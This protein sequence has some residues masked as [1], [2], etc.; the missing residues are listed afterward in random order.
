MKVRAS[1]LVSLHLF[2]FVTCFSQE[3]KTLSPDEWRQDINF[4][5]NTI[6]EVH[7]NPYWRITKESFLS[8][9]NELLKELKGMSP[10]DIQVRMIQLVASIQDGHSSLSPYGPNGFKSIFPI[11]TYQ[12]TDG[13]FITAISKEYE[14]LAGAEILKIGHLDTPS[15]LHLISTLWTNENEFEKLNGAVF[16]LTSPEALKSLKIINDINVLT[17]TV[18]LRSGEEQTIS[19]RRI[20]QEFDLSF[21]YWGEMW[22]PGE[23]EYVTGIDFLNSNSYYDQENVDLPL[24]LRYRS[25]FWFKYL[26]KERLIYLQI[27]SMGD[28]RK[29]SLSSFLNRLWA[30]V[31]TKPVDKFV[32]DIRYNV[33]GDGSR[34]NDILH[35]F[36]KRDEI[37]KSD[38]LFT[39]LGRAT[40]SAGVNLASA[41]K[42]H[43]NTTFIGSPA[44]AY[45]NHNGDAETFV[46]PNSKM[47]L[48]VSTSWHQPF[49]SRDTNRLIP[50]D[51]PIMLSS[52]EYFGKV[53][54]IMTSILNDNYQPIKD[55]IL[56]QNAAIGIR[57]YNNR[58]VK[59]GHISWWNRFTENDWNI[60]GYNLYDANK[61][62]DA[63]EVFQYNASK[64]PTSWRACDSLAETYARIGNND[65]AILWYKKALS[66]SPTNFNA[67][68]QREMIHKL[69]N[70]E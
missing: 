60:L 47:E 14:E 8:K 16:Y 66:L 34:V 42:D 17:L 20:E 33:G 13:L 43:T 45:H 44:G 1:L 19:I 10:T 63:L 50:I 25:T 29:E 38:K 15:A 57:E 51:I 24:H 2:V 36:I 64:Y 22:G 61:K 56:S 39:V 12:F 46:L 7:P 27:N 68:Y 9:K 52:S 23:I 58:E 41:M 65:E 54:P 11:R 70:K 21:I 40:F 55:L 3:S 48:Q 67:D 69:S 4:I 31:D 37:N 49:S 59:F 62:E 18:R 26:E 32:L 30:E 5:I 28:S 35:G 6:E 53:D